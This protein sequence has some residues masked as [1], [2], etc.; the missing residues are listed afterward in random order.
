M[1]F[2]LKHLTLAAVLVGAVVFLLFGDDIKFS[3]DPIPVTDEAGR[4]TKPNRQTDEEKAKEDEGG[5]SFTLTT[6]SAAKGLSGF[7]GKV[8]EELLGNSKTLGDGF[9]L[10]LDP[11]KYSLDQQLRRREE[12][13]QPGP[14]KF[15]GE[16]TNRRF[17]SGDTLKQILESATEAEGMEL[18]WR[19]D[20]DY[21]IKHYFQVESNLVDAVGTVAKALD[22]DFDTEI[23]A[24]YCSKQ[25]ALVLT[26][27]I[28]DFVRDNCRSTKKEP[29]Y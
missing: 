23:L 4:V 28:T 12:M 7:Y 3:G 24:F 2:W 10:K 14:E 17:R 6:S 1:W 15:T 18:I 16:V 26:H 9:V 20:R 25:R 8:R 22:S 19:L 11:P 21:V 29:D 13:V 5:P 27:E